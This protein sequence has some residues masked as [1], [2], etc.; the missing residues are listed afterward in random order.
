V[1]AVGS[2]EMAEITSARNSQVVDV[3]KLHRRRERRRRGKTILEGP[4]LLRA[5]VDAGGSPDIVLASIG[6]TDTRGLCIE[7]GIDCR[8]VDDAV[9]NRLAPTE[10]PRGP[11][12]VIS[13]PA[14]VPP[15][16]KDTV[17]LVGVS[18][19]GNVGTLVRSAAAFGF[20]VGVAPETAD[21]WSPKALRAGAGAH[22]GLAITQLGEDLTQELKAAGLVVVATTADGGAAEA[23]AGAAAVALMIGSEPHG[24]PEVLVEAADSRVSIP[25]MTVESLNAAVAGSIL[26]YERSRVR[27]GGIG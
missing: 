3:A 23:D 17:V 5:F 21:I 25:T 19:P 2:G 4:H 18:D 20:A 13:I 11:V 14:S 26:M 1:N 6:D 7:R 22:F 24:L 8:T 10:H 15:D 27:I 9:L 12:A 16:R